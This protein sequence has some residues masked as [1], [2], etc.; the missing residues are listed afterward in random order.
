VCE[1]IRFTCLILNFFMCFSKFQPGFKT[2]SSQNDSI[3]HSRLILGVLICDPSV[4]KSNQLHVD[5]F[6]FWFLFSLHWLYIFSSL[7][8][9]DGILN[10][11]QLFLKLNRF[12]CNYTKYDCKPTLHV[13][14]TI[15]AIPCTSLGGL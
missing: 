12:I 11:D 15:F 5:V 4:S 8:N 2:Q 3:G 9:F 10:F 7:S 13:N 1:N 6:W 14:P